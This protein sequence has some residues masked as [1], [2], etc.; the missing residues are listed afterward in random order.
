MMHLDQRHLRFARDPR[1]T[2]VA[3]GAAPLASRPRAACAAVCV[4]ALACALALPSSADA[5]WPLESAAPAALG[6]GATYAA[7]DGTPAVHRG[8]DLVAATGSAV[9]APLS[10]RVSFAGRIPG[11]GG[12]TVLAVT[13]TTARGSVT[14]MPLASASVRA[15]AQ[16]AEGDSV[17]TLDGTGDA[18]TVASHLHV[19]ARKSDLYIDPTALIAPPAPTPP[20]TVEVPDAPQPGPVVQ[21]RPSGV[22]VAAGV[23]PRGAGALAPGASA[24]RAP[25]DCG[26]G[27]GGRRRGGCAGGH[28]GPGLER[29][30]GSLDSGRGR[31]VGGAGKHAAVRERGLLGGGRGR[32]PEPPA[33]GVGRRGAHRVG[34]RCGRAR[35]ADGRTRARDRTAGARRTVA[36]L[37]KRAEER[38]RSAFSQTRQR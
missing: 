34:A 4:G 23:A 8:I 2:R 6:F 10:G 1:E 20:P 38:C 29:R 37:A 21:A 30:S 32:G 31:A 36:D 7:A 33:A 14:L 22:G 19:G 24:A 9:R 25:A 15:G 27:V 12:G 5:G 28:S 17:G 16:L 26:A 35:P 18:S 3:T 11:T 13:I